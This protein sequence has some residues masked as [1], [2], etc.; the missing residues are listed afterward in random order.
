[1]GNIIRT[2]PNVI[3]EFKFST[4]EDAKRYYP[5]AENEKILL[6]G[7]VDLAIIDE[8]GI[9]VLDFKTDYTTE[10]SLLL[11]SEKYKSQVKAY[12]NALSRIYQ[13]PIKSAL[14]YFFSLNRFVEV[15]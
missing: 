3:R 8:D 11:I 9:V 4:L 1:M 7:V 13:K 15:L 2:S 10:E 5:D 14:L 12:G 6:Q